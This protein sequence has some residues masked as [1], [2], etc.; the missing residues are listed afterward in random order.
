MRRSPNVIGCTG[1]V[2]LVRCYD[3]IMEIRYI[4]KQFLGPVMLWI[5]ALQQW[6]AEFCSVTIYVPAFICR[7][8]DF[9][10][11]ASPQLVISG[12]DW[13]SNVDP[14]GFIPNYSVFKNI[15]SVVGW[16]LPGPMQNSEEGVSEQAKTAFFVLLLT[17]LVFFLD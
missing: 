9:S 15:Y 4:N 12:H 17:V 8:Q 3:L 2:V 14:Y 6:P 11:G 1:D 10:D 5:A 7:I 13:A 16:F